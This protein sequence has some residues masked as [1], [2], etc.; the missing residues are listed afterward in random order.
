MTP[1]VAG[2]K[3]FFEI[4]TGFYRGVMRSK[5]DEKSVSRTK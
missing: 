2:Y 4:E 5:G 3:S 1:P